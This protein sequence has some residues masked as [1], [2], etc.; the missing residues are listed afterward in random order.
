MIKHLGIIGASQFKLGVVPKDF[1][2]KVQRVR[3]ASSGALPQG[4]GSLSAAL[5]RLILVEFHLRVNSVNSFD[6]SR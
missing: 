6:S 1:Q 2:W 4:P 3:C 5:L